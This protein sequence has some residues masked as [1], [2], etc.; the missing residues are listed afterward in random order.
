MQKELDIIYFFG[1]EKGVMQPIGVIHRLTLMPDNTV[2]IKMCPIDDIPKL[3]HGTNDPRVLKEINDYVNTLNYKIY[4]KRENP[5]NATNIV[6]YF[7]QHSEETEARG[8]GMILSSRKEHNMS[9]DFDTF[10]RGGKRQM[11]DNMVW[12]T[13][14]FSFK[15]DE[16]SIL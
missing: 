4:P 5:L 6:L 9:S 14:G 7:I 13:K 1:T 3:A 12:F 16:K 11:L 2:E 8:E 15:N 10:F